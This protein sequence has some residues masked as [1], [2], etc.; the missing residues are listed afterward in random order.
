MGFEIR[1][2]G[3]FCMG[4]IL[5][6]PAI[7]SADPTWGISQSTPIDGLHNPYGLSATELD[8]SIARGR[9]WI[10]AYPVETTSSLIPIQPIKNFFDLPDSNPIRDL[11]RQVLQFSSGF[12][13]FDDILAWVGMNPYPSSDDPLAALLPEV[14]PGAKASRMG[15]SVHERN[16]A[17]G[18][19]IA[20]AACH[21]SSLFGRT[22]V[23]LQNR[24]PRVNELFLR[25]RPLVE[26]ASPWVYSLATRATAEET[27]LY[28]EQRDN[29]P[30][31]NTRK[32]VA[33]GLDTSLPQIAL[34]LDRRGTDDYASK[35][36]EAAGHPRA[37]ALDQNPADSKPGTW[38]NVRYK[39]RWL[40]DGSVVSGN[41]IF[42]NLLWNEI[43]HGSDLHQVET[44][45]SQNA[46]IVEDLAN[47]VFETEAPRYTDFFP[48]DSISIVSA[49]RGE[50]LFNQNCT[51]CHG[52]YEKAW[53]QAGADALPLAEQLK[54]AHVLY[55]EQTPVV[56]VGTDSYRWKGM[57]SLSS[58]LNHL[59][60]SKR[61][62]I[63]VEPQ[64]GYV[65]PPLVGVWARWPYFHNNSAPTLCAVLTAGSKRPPSYWSGEA[66]DRARDFDA[67]CN[68]YPLGSQTPDE[69]KKD[70]DHFYDTS[71]RGMSNSGHDEG[72]FLRDGNEIF[73][74]ADKR[75]LIQFL[76]TL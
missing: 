25:G 33:L 17:Q 49:K 30:W 21:T 38:W 8:A 67:D 24:F 23:G 11:V 7:A 61:Y 6:A 73:T 5:F 75:D 76:K 63:V 53:S 42:T 57:T 40:L 22:I 28:R 41:P 37:D 27:D 15:L 45:L 68:G 16:G 55:P 46:S 52:R 44:W 3:F 20:C 69:W 65:P 74:A 35:T 39:N 2:Y 48:A 50:I 54:T 62:E 18:F 13:S 9:R 58:Q 51:A 14:Y 43:G 10:L 26:K 29:L 64:K 72:V 47:L 70:P 4:L 59:T 19:T 66:L 1:R 60:L 31:M 32:P 34:S 71:L 36:P 12:K 56:D